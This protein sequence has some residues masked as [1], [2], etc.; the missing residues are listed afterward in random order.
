M[1]YF[2]R[3]LLTKFI[4]S[5]AGIGCGVHPMGVRHSARGQKDRGGAGGGGGETIVP[6]VRVKSGAIFGGTRLTCY[7]C[8]RE[9]GAQRRG[10]G[11]SGSS[12]AR[13]GRT[14]FFSATCLPKV[15]VLFFS[16]PPLYRLLTTR[17]ELLITPRQVLLSLF[18]PLG[19]T[20]FSGNIL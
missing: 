8:Q 11:N 6:R 20:F 5:Q 7:F 2:N 13:G 16:S 3:L 15:S 18:A 4:R 19:F 10:G 12:G 9:S 14:L 17:A 1:H